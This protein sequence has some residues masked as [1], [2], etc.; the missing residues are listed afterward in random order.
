MR[1]MLYLMLF[2]IILKLSVRTSKKTR[3]T[4][5]TKINQL[6]PFREIIAVYSENHMKATNTLF[7]QNIELLI[8]K[9][10]GTYSYSW[11]LKG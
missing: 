4:I 10:R 7:L 3:P 1:G 8:M 5:I 11:A 2:L 6:T 9:A